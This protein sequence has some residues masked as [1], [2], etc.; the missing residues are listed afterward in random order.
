MSHTKALRYSRWERLVFRVTG[1]WP[2]RVVDRR[3]NALARDRIKLDS[4]EARRVFWGAQ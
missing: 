3:L 1:R 2:D 4:D